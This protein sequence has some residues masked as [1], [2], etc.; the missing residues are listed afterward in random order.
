[1]KVK[2]AEYIVNAFENV[3][4]LKDDPMPYDDHCDHNQKQHPNNHHSNKLYKA[5]AIKELNT[6]QS[7]KF[8]TYSSQGSSTS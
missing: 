6:E 3:K 1:M 5:N 4:N 8:D 2:L 7:S